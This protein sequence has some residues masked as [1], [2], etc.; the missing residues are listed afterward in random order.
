MLEGASNKLRKD[1]ICVIDIAKTISWKNE[2]QPW[3]GAKETEKI[4]KQFNFIKLRE[5]TYR[6]KEEQETHEKDRKHSHEQHILVFALGINTYDQSLPHSNASPFRDEYT[7]GVEGW[8]ERYWPSELIDDYISVFELREKII[9]DPFMGSALIAFRSDRYNCFFI[10][11]EVSEAAYKLV[12]DRKKM[13]MR[14]DIDTIRACF[15]K[16]FKYFGKKCEPASEGKE[17][18]L[19]PGE[20]L[21]YV[22][23]A[24]EDYNTKKCHPEL[25]VSK[26]YGPKAEIEERKKR[27]NSFLNEI[28]LKDGNLLSQI[29]IYKMGLQGESSSPLIL[30]FDNETT[31]IQVGSKKYHNIDKFCNEF[32]LGKDAKGAIE[33]HF[34]LLNVEEKNTYFGF[35]PLLINH[36]SVQT[37]AVAYITICGVDFSNKTIHSF[38][39]ALLREFRH[40]AIDFIFRR[41]ETLTELQKNSARRA[42]SSA[43]LARN[44]SHNIGS[45][46]TPRSWTG[47]IRKR[48]EDLFPGDVSWENKFKAIQTVKDR[49]DEYRQRKAE[50][51][52]DI[53]TEPMMSTKS[54]MFFSEVVV[55]FTQNTGLIDT[56][57]ANEGFGYRKYDSSGV[58]IHCF[59]RKNGVNIPIKTIYKTKYKSIETSSVPYALRYGEGRSVT[60]VSLSEIV[61]E[62]ET[63]MM[64]A[65]DDYVVTLPGPVGEMAFYS[66]LENY[67]RNTAKHGHHKHDGKNPLVIN[68]AIEDDK[69][70]NCYKLYIWENLS[71]HAK[72]KDI[73][74]LPNTINKINEYIKSD[75]IDDM[76]EKREKA[77]GIAEMTICAALLQGEKN[78]DF[79]GVCDLKVLSLKKIFGNSENHDGLLYRMKLLKTKAAVF[80]GCLTPEN[81]LKKKYMKHG[82]IFYNSIEEF[83]K[84]CNSE[85]LLASSFQFA[86][87]Q[88]EIIK[89][90]QP[91]EIEDLLR[92]LPFRII[93][94]G[95]MKDMHIFN[96]EKRFVSVENPPLGNSP[97]E[98]LKLLWEIWLGRW[99][100]K[101][102]IEDFGVDIYLQQKKDER[103]TTRWIKYANEFNKDT[104]S[105]VDLRIWEGISNPSNCQIETT[106]STQA[107]KSRRLFFDRH[108]ILSKKIGGEIGAPNNRYI[109]LDKANSDFEHIFNPPTSRPWV[110]PYQLIE[111]GLLNMLIIDERIAERSLEEMPIDGHSDELSKTFRGETNYSKGPLL[112]WYAAQKAGLFIGTHLV[113]KNDS[114]TTGTLT[115]KD[116]TVCLCPQKWEET[117]KKFQ[118]ESA[119][120]LPKMEICIKLNSK[121][122]CVSLSVTRSMEDITNKSSLENELIDNIDMVIV[123]QGVLDV[124]D[125][126]KKPEFNLLKCL[127]E[128]FPWTI[129][130]SGRGI[131]PEVQRSR[132]DKFVSF[133]VIGN[134]VR[135]GR[136]GK[137]GLTKT[138]MELVRFG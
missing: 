60:D 94:S 55:P 74:D 49:I 19:G 91:E 99:C 29:L 59:I 11:Y 83:N 26:Y 28:D 33:S 68:I 78:F 138:M 66:F 62:D 133:S 75:I 116:K 14:G 97:E 123:H 31:T 121:N 117:I 87:I 38:R 112:S 137:V 5:Y 131:P 48:Y 119:P 36:K 35:F 20:R 22:G 15:T 42:A 130:E 10:G 3:H 132:Q 96:A 4:A 92:Q 50:F 69:N 128:Y 46:V 65:I 124:V 57:A 8:D 47:D 1:G 70:Q 44:M 98:C 107:S 43:F 45:H 56:L 93:I 37:S 106:R 40:A 103:P 73:T 135:N 129:V 76:G 9:L 90:K 67:I 32:K 81:A 105:N 58:Q 27:L 6:S 109:I 104:S 25:I 111:A 113:I 110:F 16:Y 63:G 12:E 34:N 18:L 52:A 72:V 17:T 86:V 136:I 39:N 64:S 126:K 88:S 21:L 134:S 115:E 100:T 77:W 84:K 2:Q 51:I 102:K 122:S 80:L 120:Y 85:D 89:T 95:D 101:N 61:I 82:F 108:A 125:A 114:N 23:A 127:K 7:F 53:T 24:F 41:I 54:A 71:D 79:P 118:H 13:E 30:R